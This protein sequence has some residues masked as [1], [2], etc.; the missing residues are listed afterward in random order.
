LIPS[1]SDLRGG[2]TEGEPTVVFPTF[3]STAALINLCLSNGGARK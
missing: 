3:L 1:C 2:E